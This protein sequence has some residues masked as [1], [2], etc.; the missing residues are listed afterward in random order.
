MTTT[1]SPERFSP[2]GTPTVTFA[3]D[4]MSCGH[5]VGAVTGAL[6]GTPGISVRS[7]AIGTAEV[8]ADS[9]AAATTALAAI[10]AAG[11]TAEVVASAPPTAR[12]GCGC[13]GTSKAA[14]PCA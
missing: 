4:G 11:Y 7:V 8:E 5:C 6:E 13:C 14:R 1:P 12:S 2:A 9:P 10:E 3:I